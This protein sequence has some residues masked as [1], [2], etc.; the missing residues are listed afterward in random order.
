MLR[1]GGTAS[2]ASNPPA[3][4]SELLF[5]EFIGGCILV[6]STARQ[7]ESKRQ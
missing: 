6:V 4:Y 1:I 2:D 3:F 5:E 7:W